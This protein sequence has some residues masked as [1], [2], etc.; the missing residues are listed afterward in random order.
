MHLEL[1]RPAL[2]HQ[3]VLDANVVSKALSQAAV[4]FAVPAHVHTGEALGGDERRQGSG[5]SLAAAPQLAV[6]FSA[7]LRAFGSINTVEA[8]FHAMPDH[9]I[10]IG[11][12]KIVGSGCAGNC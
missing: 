10:G 7:D 3:P 6:G 9:R 5:G 11:Q 12:A 2:L 4:V 8:I 1:D